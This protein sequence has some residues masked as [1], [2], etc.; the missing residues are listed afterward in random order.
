M[1]MKFVACSIFALLSLPCSHAIW[2]QQNDDGNPFGES[3]NTSSPVDP[4]TTKE[5]AL[6]SDPFAN[7]PSVRSLPDVNSQPDSPVHGNPKQ[8]G[9]V[10]TMTDADP[11]AKIYE[12]LQSQ[13]GMDWGYADSPLSDVVD[14][15]RE[16]Y[17]VNV[18]LDLNALEEAGLAPDLPITS[19]L[20]GVTLQ[21]AL[22]MIFRQHDLAFT[23]HSGVLIITTK[24]GADTNLS[25]ETFDVSDFYRE[26]EP[27]AFVFNPVWSGVRQGKSDLREIVIAVVSPDSWE[28]NGGIGTLSVIELGG[29][30]LMVVSQTTA[31]LMQ[32]RR[33]MR[34]LRITA[35]APIDAV[36]E[37]AVAASTGSRIYR[38]AKDEETK[39][40][41]LANLVVKALDANQTEGAQVREANGRVEAHGNHLLV[42]GTRKFHDHVY[43][44]L[45][46]LGALD[47]S[48]V[49]DSMPESTQQT[50]GPVPAGGGGMFNVKRSGESQ[51]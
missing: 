37:K 47:H 48:N 23:I 11:N 19:S 8:D 45:N 17:A 44:V 18:V 40:S 16:V 7:S 2:F 14:N 35:G 30:K 21:T 12:A 15:I 51:N 22:E 9:L 49:R 38:L 50:P 3:K 1:A 41:D 39:P 28:V 33:L 32:V 25:H 24:D 42:E 34:E 36:D 4:K 10:V 6:T 43:I 13:V 31:G 46:D 27:S 29:K 20:V 5:A 26:T